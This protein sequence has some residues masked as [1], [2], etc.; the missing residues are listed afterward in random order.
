M[1]FLPLLL[2]KSNRNN[3]TIVAEGKILP[4]FRET[5]S[6]ILTFGLTVFA[7]IFF[8]AENMLHATNYIS[9]IFSSSL[10]SI[11]EVRPKTTILLVAVLLIT[12][13]FGREGKF[14]L[15][16]ICIS[17]PALLR[18]ST[19]IIIGLIFIFGNFNK[20]EFIYFAF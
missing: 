12:E 1:Y 6:L 13:W 10:I 14:A 7:W 15:E 3:M 11:P 9:E 2:T 20:A 18:A 5:R 17:F 19:Y 8:R 16:G 4:S